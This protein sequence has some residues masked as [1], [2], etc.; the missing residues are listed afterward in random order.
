MVHRSLSPCTPVNPVP[1]PDALP[2]AWIG[3]GLSG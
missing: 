3:L 2:L 1:L